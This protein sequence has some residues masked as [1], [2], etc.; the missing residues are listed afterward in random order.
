MDVEKVERHGREETV[1]CELRNCSN[2]WTKKMVRKGKSPTHFAVM[3]Y[4]L[5]EEGRRFLPLVLV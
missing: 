1:D 4:G 5:E 3:A 2:R